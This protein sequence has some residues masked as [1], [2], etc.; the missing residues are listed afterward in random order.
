MATLPPVATNWLPA[1]NEAK[2]GKREI[3]KLVNQLRRKLMGTSPGSGLALFSTAIGR[4]DVI[5]SLTDGNEVIG[6]SFQLPVVYS[7][8]TISFSGE[9][10]D[11]GSGGI[12]RIRMGGTYGIASSGTVI[13][14]LNAS[15]ATFVVASVITP[16]TSNPAT[17]LQM[18]VQS[19]VG[20]TAQFREGF[21]SGN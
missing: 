1:L 20:N 10:A 14:T 8:F 7:A 4:G 9:I 17:L 18:T 16:V 12:F 13:A 19:T 15:A 3:V 2:D 21:V 11:S 5:R 6:L